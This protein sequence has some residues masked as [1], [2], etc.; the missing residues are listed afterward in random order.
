VRL[1]ARGARDLD[2]GLTAVPNLEEAGVLRAQGARIYAVSIAGALLLTGLGL[3]LV[4]M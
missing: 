3:L 4:G 2:G 1:A